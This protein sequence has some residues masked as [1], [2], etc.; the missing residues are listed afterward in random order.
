MKAFSRLVPQR[1]LEA[2]A[3]GRVNAIFAT[4]E[5]A[6]DEHRLLPGCFVANWKGR[7][8]NGLTGYEKIGRPLLRAHALDENAVGRV[9]NL[10]ETTDGKLMGAA[11]FAPTATGQELATL[12]ESGFQSSFSISWLPVEFSYSTDKTRGPGAI[13]FKRAKLLE[14][15]C[16]PVPSDMGA[17]VQRAQDGDLKGAAISLGISLAIR[18]IEPHVADIAIREAGRALQ[19]DSFVRGVAERATFFAIAHNTFAGLRRGQK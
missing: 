1:K 18:E 3:A 12:Y 6:L 7:G 15:S 9:E 17:T 8:E 10:R 19:A 4:S 11:V 14:I 2:D 16:V 13:D 5:V